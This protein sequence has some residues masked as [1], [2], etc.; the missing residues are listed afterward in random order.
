MQDW[1]PDGY[2]QPERQSFAAAHS[3]KDYEFQMYTY[4]CCPVNEICGRNGFGIA[5]ALTGYP[6]PIEQQ[7][8]QHAGIIVLHSAIL[9]HTPHYFHTPAIVAFLTDQLHTD[10]ESYLR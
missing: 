6:R 1:R 8:F 3:E 10:N 2:G 4:G 7:V 5:L 9:F